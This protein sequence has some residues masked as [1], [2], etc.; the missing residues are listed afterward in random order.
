MKSKFWGRTLFGWFLRGYR[1]L[2]RHPQHR[3]W[4]MA[5]TLL[6]LLGPVDLAPDML[7]LV[8]WVDDGLLVTLL[9]TELSQVMVSELKARKRATAAATGDGSTPTSAVPAPMSS[10]PVIDI[11]AMSV[12]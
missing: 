11:D 4:V 2:I 12:I 6:Y 10:Q 8:G 5:G 7:P 3:W 1:A 9:V